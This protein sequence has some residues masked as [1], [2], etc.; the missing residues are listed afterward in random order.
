M[1]NTCF[2][3]FL[4]S[5]IHTLAA[6]CVTAFA[7]IVAPLPSA[8]QP[9]TRGIGKYPGRLSEFYGPRPVQTEAS[10]AASVNLALHRS[11]LA[12]STAD[13]NFTAHLATDGIVDDHEPA[14]LV[15]STPKGQLPKREV[16]WAIDGGPYSNNVLMG[17]RTWLRY[18][19]GGEQTLTARAVRLD[20]RVAYHEVKTKSGYSISVQASDD[21]NTWTTVGQLSGKGLPGRAANYLLSSDPNKQTSTDM[22]PA[23]MLEQT[24]R[25]D[26]TTRFRHFRLV[27]E[28]T[29]AEYWA[30]HNL[31]F[32]DDV[33]QEV[34]GLPSQEFASMWMSAGGGHQ[35]LRIDLGAPSQVEKVVPH[36]YQEPKRW[37]YDVADDGSSVTIVMD[38]PGDAGFYALRE[39]EVWGR[40]SQRLTP[41]PERGWKDNRFELSGGQWQLQRASEVKATG[42]EL[43]VPTFDSSSWLWATVPGTVLM[44]YVN[45]GAVPDPNCADYVDQISES[46]FRSNFWYRDVF[47]WSPRGDGE[48]SYLN[49]DGINWKANVWLNGQYLGRIDGAFCRGRF[50]VTGLLAEGKN[51]LA[52]EILCNEHFG[53]VKEKDA[54]TTQF[55]GGILGADNPT[56]HATIGWDWITTVRGRNAGIWNEV[57]ITREGSVSLSDPYVATHIGEKVEVTPAV[58]VRNNTSLPVLGRLC[59]WIGDIR[60]ERNI[61]LPANSEQEVRFAPEDF[62]QLADVHLPLWWP[63]GYGEPVLHDAGFEIKPITRLSTL[64]EELSA[65]NFQLSTLNYKAGLRE[66]TYDGLGDSLLI[67]VNGRRF[68][69]LGGNWGMDEHNL[70]YRRREYDAAVSFH[71]SMHATMIRNWVGMTGDD[72][73]YRACDSLGI[74]VWQDFWLANPVDGPNPYDEGMFLNNAYDYVR[75]IRQHASLGLFCGR[76][77]GY[78]P[79]TIDRGLRHY[80]ADLTPGLGY[81]PSSADDGITGHG[82]Y[83][84]QPARVYFE[85]QSGK[86]HTERGMPNVMNYEN[87]A[88][89]LDK[90]SLW[91]QST[92]WGQHDYTLKGA[93]R[94]SEFNDLVN[95]GFGPSQ[96]AHEFTRRAQLINYNG[97]RAMFESTSISRAGLLIWMSHPCWPTMVWQTYDYYFEPTAAFFGMKKAC[98]SLHIQLNALTNRVEVVNSFAG[99]RAKLTATATAYDLNGR[100]LWSQSQRLAAKDDTTVPLFAIADKARQADCAVLRLELHEGKTLVSQNDYF[101]GR[102]DGD[103]KALLGLPAAK[104]EQTTTLAAKGDVCTA[105]VVVANRSRSVAPF[106]R[107]NLL[108]A[109]GEQILPA[110]YSDNYFNLLP[111]ERRT[112]T[113]TWKKEDGRGQ[114]PRVNIEPINATD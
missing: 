11:A 38:E 28:M 107:L 20:A 57:Y 56:F 42:E 35:W 46:F 63:N 102:T 17:E 109:D 16:E 77:E 64:S 51:A 15:A 114:A 71:R 112:I 5:G 106:L 85:R 88:R 58:F 12:S 54:N 101:V 53:V 29:G 83:C 1:T 111:S 40:P 47:E 103:Y 65:L 100:R 24:I 80:V 10:S 25:L 59:G 44:S 41:C 86:I 99:D 96:S 73:F 81:I 113:I 89:T 6:C 23:R 9:Y 93:Q 62:P 60:F 18:D 78:P 26:K 105:T 70:C 95:H 3:C 13:Y 31:H 91:P 87:L 68:V 67:Y 75:R 45:A 27:V 33:G 34:W 50:D 79:A 69:P 48:R 94:A 49:F 98:E 76:N 66:M 19:W 90:D 104:I 74:M 110:D 22:L 30:I 8:A 82:P 55:N 97:Y 32:L 14:L 92:Q 43:S 72:D 36:W 7:F 52:V 4:H 61:Q 21:G 84:A 2:R 108:G 39:V 37:H